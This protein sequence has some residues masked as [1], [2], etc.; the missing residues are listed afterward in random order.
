M[1]WKKEPDCF[2]NTLRQIV[3]PTKGGY[4]C[5]EPTGEG[6]MLDTAKG[7]LNW[8]TRLTASITMPTVYS[9]DRWA[10]RR[11]TLEELG[12]AADIP[13]DKVEGMGAGSL[14]VAVNA[15]VPGKLLALIANSLRKTL[16]KDEAIEARETGKRERGDVEACVAKKRRTAIERDPRE[17]RM[18]DWAREKSG[19]RNSEEEPGVICR[20][21]KK[22]R[23]DGETVEVKVMEDGDRKAEALPT[24]IGDANRTTVTAKAV[25][26][27]NAKIPKSLWNNRVFALD[28]MEEV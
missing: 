6:S 7:L 3:D 21:G 18:F 20:H 14:K 27:D 17:D 8:G 2:K 5:D 9:K 25:K 26:S 15:P 1:R 13:G 28:S 11:L 19:K 10:R 4:M 24:T 12:H 22:A 16:G 23:V